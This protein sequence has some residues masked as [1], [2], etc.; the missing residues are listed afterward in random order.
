MAV[1]IG[2]T[3]FLARALG[4][5]R[6]WAGVDAEAIVSAIKVEPGDNGND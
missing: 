4:R 2:L 3:V 6:G 1:K 5:N